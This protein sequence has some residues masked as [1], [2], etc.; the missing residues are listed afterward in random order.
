LDKKCKID[1]VAWSHQKDIGKLL[2]SALW[3]TSY[4]QPTTRNSG[5][6]PSLDLPTSAGTPV[7]AIHDGEVISAGERNGYGLSITIKHIF[8]NETIFSN[9][10]HLSEM[11][12]TPGTKVTWKMLIGKVG[13]TW[14]SISGD[15]TRCGNHL[16]FQI[17]TAKSPSHPYG[18]GDCKEGDYFDAVAAWLCKEKLLA[19][20]IDPLVFFVEHTDIA[21]N[22]P[23]I[24]PY[25]VKN[26]QEHSAAPTEETKKPT[27]KSIFARLRAQNNALIWHSSLPPTPNEQWTTTTSTLATTV[28]P[29]Q[30]T[31]IT[32]V[33][34]SKE[35][36][37]IDIWTIKRSWNTE[38]T[39]LTTYKVVT[40]SIS[41]TDKLGNP[42]IGNLPQTFKVTLDN[43]EVGSFF[44]DQ[45]T[46]LPSEKKY[47]FFQTQNTGEATLI[48]WYGNTKIGEEKVRV[49]ESWV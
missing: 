9:Y 37:V 27:L 41:V 47:L 20:T 12:V 32:P 42:F 10:S 33:V 30:T 13:C 11:L 35:K 25:I 15:P 17:T 6:H 3:W 7:Y 8:K 40:L 38:L 28:T 44:P 14:F 36:A 1:I 22:Y 23:L 45:F 18:Y 4:E 19:Y 31:N 29:P 48:L 43:N 16:D 26:K 46:S 2:F 49:N 39:N 5:G 24:A 34:N 21:I